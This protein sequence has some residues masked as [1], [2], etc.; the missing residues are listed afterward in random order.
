MSG[1]KDVSGQEIEPGDWIV[2]SLGDG[3]MKFA[4]VVGIGKTN[5]ARAVSFEFHRVYRRIVDPSTG[6]VR[7]GYDDHPS[8]ERSGPYTIKHS[9]R[10][11]VIDPSRAPRELLNHI[12]VDLKGDPLYDPEYHVI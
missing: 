11:F 10:I 6:K 5:K 4:I 7:H 2:Q 12:D 9:E 1:P 3:T 8:W